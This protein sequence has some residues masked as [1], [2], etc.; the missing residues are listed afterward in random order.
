M[1]TERRK[2]LFYF[3]PEY[4]GERWVGLT[5]DDIILQMQGIRKIRLSAHLTQVSVYMPPW[6]KCG[7]GFSRSSINRTGAYSFFSQALS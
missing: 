2:I 1:A 6:P 3:F 4:V 5:I 7:Q